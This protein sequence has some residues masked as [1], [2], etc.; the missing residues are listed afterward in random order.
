M[1]LFYLDY[2]ILCHFSL[3]SHCVTMYLEKI[4]NFV[5]YYLN[6]FCETE[7]KGPWTCKQTD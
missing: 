6:P 5:L 3:I 1:I 2:N 7:E 4:K